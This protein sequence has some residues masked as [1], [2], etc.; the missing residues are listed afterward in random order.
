[1]EYPDYTKLEVEDWVNSLGVVFF[2]T[3]GLKE[4]QI[5]LDFGCG[6]GNYCLPAAKVVGSKGKVY[7][8]DKAIGNGYDPITHLIPRAKEMGL[9]AIITPMKTEGELAI[10]L[11]DDSVDLILLLDV[12]HGVMEQDSPQQPNSL[13]MLMQEFSRVLRDGGRFLLTIHHLEATKFSLEE[14]IAEIRCLFDSM[15]NKRITML[16]WDFLR[17]EML[18]IFSKNS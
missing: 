2:N 12:L 7:A 1:M 14:I 17:E 11:P 8:L 6:V 4:G 9:E 15:E 10:D 3:L 5:L 16:H 18:Y 13:R